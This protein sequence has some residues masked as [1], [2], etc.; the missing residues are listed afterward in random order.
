[1]PYCVIFNRKVLPTLRAML[2]IKLVEEYGLSQVEVAR[3]L[4][5]KQSLVNYIVTGKRKAKYMDKI[6]KLEEVNKLVEE[7][8][9]EIARNK[10]GPNLCEV[11]EYIFSSDLASK[12]IKAVGEEPA[13]VL[14][15]RFRE[16]GL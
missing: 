6:A 14:S 1:M 11:C 8:S 2:A 4:G 13:L 3:Y 10:R 12:I 16:K 15:P 5:V 9:R 7:L